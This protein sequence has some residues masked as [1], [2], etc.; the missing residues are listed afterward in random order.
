LKE[1]DIT[2]DLDSEKQKIM[3][4]IESFVEERN[5]DG[6][7][8][9]FSG[10]IDST[11]VTKLCI[12]VLGEEKVKLFLRPE[13]FYDDYE[14]ICKTSL[15]YLEIS[16]N[17]VERCEIDDITDKFS[18]EPLVRGSTREVPRVSGP[19]SYSLLKGVPI[20][21]SEG[22][23]YGMPGKAVTGRDE[24]IN[25]IVAHNKLRSRIQMASAY[26]IAEN[27]NRG[28]ISTLNKTEFMTG[29]FT[30][31]GRGQSAD[32][33]PLGHL[34]RTQILQLAEYLKV[35]S[36]IQNRAKVDL[37]PGVENKYQYFFNLAAYDVDRILVRLETGHSI[38]DIQTELK[39]PLEKITK[40]NTFYTSSAYSRSAP[41]TIK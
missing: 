38:I 23:T 25:R 40:M 10:F 22:K 28:L 5:L 1:L 7:L 9:W 24:L 21:E 35:P 19:L 33:M 37:L 30:K 18:S 41:L 26:L 13:K 2:T 29:L 27:E 15:E 32:L 12:E 31:F 20:S 34:Y 14:E 17:H 39:L 4:F 8:I 6:V 3:N 16:E 11:I 36:L